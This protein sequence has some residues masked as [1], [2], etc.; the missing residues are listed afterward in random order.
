MPSS[1]YGAGSFAMILWER[2]KSRR[3]DQVFK[4]FGKV[5]EVGKSALALGFLAL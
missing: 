2:R 4:V 3:I 5:L 1:M